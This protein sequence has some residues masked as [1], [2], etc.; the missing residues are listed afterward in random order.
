MPLEKSNTP[1]VFTRITE[2]K[3]STVIEMLSS[4]QVLSHK[5]KKSEWK[6]RAEKVLGEYFLDKL[7]KFGDQYQLP[8]AVFELAI[9]FAEPHDVPGFI[10]WVNTMPEKELAFYLLGRLYPL[11]ILPDSI[12][13]ESI[14]S[15][16]HNNPPGACSGCITDP[17][18]W[19]RDISSMR[20]RLVRLWKDYW[21]NFFKKDSLFYPEKW[22]S[23]LKNLEQKLMR[24]GGKALY[25]DFFNTLEFP[26]EVP[27]G[28]P[29]KEI[30]YVPVYRSV[31]NQLKFFGYG[32][33]TILYNCR[34]NE[35]ISKSIEHAGQK[36]LAMARALGDE[37]RI[38]ILKLIANNTFGLNG[39]SLAKKM[40]LSPSVV[41]R[42]LA[43]LKNSGL[44]IE[45]SE[46][47]R[48]IMYSLN[49]ENI[50][51]LSN[52]LLQYFGESV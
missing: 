47:N 25:Q 35:E 51:D 7:K 39:K 6:E 3:T 17:V 42:H 24:S 27:R 13:R 10:E 30:R 23:S 22:E 28:M 48:A 49:W 44:I 38:K 9:D 12:T 43:Q 11:E 32:N 18:Y 33:I 2:L 37:R 15:T 36:A 40:G 21:E 46:D 41:S 26:P 5:W 34:I 19:A 8:T 31:I 29:Y 1:D 52:L 4:L 20:R 16:I 45:K 50:Q 14:N